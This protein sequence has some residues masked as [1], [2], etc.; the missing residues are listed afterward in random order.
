MPYLSMYFSKV[1][2]AIL[3]WK[4]AWAMEFLEIKMHIQ[5]P[6]ASEPTMESSH[7]G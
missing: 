3:I 6:K 7:I 1:E 4:Y 5:H 2:S